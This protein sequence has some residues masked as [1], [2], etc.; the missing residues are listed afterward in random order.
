[1]IRKGN[2]SKITIQPEDIEVDTDAIRVSEYRIDE[3][4]CPNEHSNGNPV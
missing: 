2:I 4:W 1:M 3:R